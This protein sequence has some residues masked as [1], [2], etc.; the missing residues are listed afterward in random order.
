MS[1]VEPV[2]KV[3]N[4]KVY[5]KRGGGIFKKPSIVRA[6]DGVS[7][8]IYRGEVLGLVGESG[9]GKSSIARGIL[10]LAEPEEGEVFLNG[11]NFLKLKGK[12]LRQERRHIQMVFQ[13]PYTSLNPRLKV[14][15]I[16]EEPLIVHRIGTKTDRRKKVAE[17][18]KMMGL[19]EEDI[20]KYP[21][22]FSGGQRQR[23]AIARAIILNPDVLI[24]DEPTSALD[25]SV[26][27]QIINLFIDLKEKFNIAYLFIS[28][29]LRLIEFISHRI[30][31]MYSGEFVELGSRNEIIDSPLHPYT[32]VLLNTAPTLDIDKKRKKI[33]LPGE[34]PS[35]ENPPSGCRFHPRCPKR[36]S[37]CDREKPALREI[38]SGH[39][40][41]C[42]LYQ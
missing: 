13:D 42:H 17:M 2:L 25:V 26:Q 6:V 19:H 29:D 7:F 38:K 41:S 39:F 16:V 28:H 10:R 12:E 36:F 33:I 15:Y 4:L 9:C 11:K 32:E 27:A 34:V 21:H 40:V 31:V 30:A 5:F 1:D 22:Q 35:P 23:I 14:G 24:A 3:K 20:N 18:F 8:N 37:P